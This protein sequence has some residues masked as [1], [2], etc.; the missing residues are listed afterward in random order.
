M[1]GVWA[2][3]DAAYGLCAALGLWLG[4]GAALRLRRARRG[5]ARIEGS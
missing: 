5:L 2:Y 3:V 1:S 4:V